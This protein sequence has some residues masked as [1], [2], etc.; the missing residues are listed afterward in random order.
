MDLP[1][2]SVESDQDGYVVAARNPQASSV[3]VSWTFTEDGSDA[4]TTVAS[5][6]ADRGARQRG[7]PVQRDIPQRS[8]IDARAQAL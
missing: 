2:R 1:E 3:N 4:V 5:S 6:G 8:L 7:R